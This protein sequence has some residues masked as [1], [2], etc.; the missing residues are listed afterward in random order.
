LR[1]KRMRMWLIHGLTCVDIILTGRGC[2]Q[3]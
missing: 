3:C 1:E 2:G